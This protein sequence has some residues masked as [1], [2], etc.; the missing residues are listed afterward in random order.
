MWPLPR[1]LI[2]PQPP[3]RGC[4]LGWGAEEGVGLHRGREAGDGNR[5]SAQKLAGE[6]SRR[7]GRAAGGRGGVGAGTF[8]L[9]GSIRL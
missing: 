6:I 4:S 5:K 8:M 7:V 9:L 3:A 1:G 2:G